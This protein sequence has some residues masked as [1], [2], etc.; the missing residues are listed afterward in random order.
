MN[1]RPRCTAIHEAGHALAFWWNGQPIAR[2]SVRTRAEAAAGPMLD[3]RGNPRYVEGLVEADYLVPRPAFDAPG[4]AEYLPSMVE[5]IERDLLHCFAGPVAEA[6]Y[7]HGRSDRLIKGSG[8]GDL[9]RGHELIS[10]LPPRKLLDAE[11][12][13]TARASCLVHRYWSA[14]GAVADLLQEHGTVEGQTISALLC[15][16]SGESPAPLGNDLASL[17]P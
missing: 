13:A 3:L 6:I 15:A 11:S 9:S 17:D 2:V 14:V 4:I 16:I 7:R 10:L 12:R 5:S 8:R 1:Q